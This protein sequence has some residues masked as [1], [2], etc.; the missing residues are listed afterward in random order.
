MMLAS[1]LQ[2]YFIDDKF[3]KGKFAIIFMI[4]SFPHCF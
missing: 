3:L 1:M 2:S 4:E